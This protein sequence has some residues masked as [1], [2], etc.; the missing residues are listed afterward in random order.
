VADKK[1]MAKKSA[2]QKARKREAKQLR[3][4]FEALSA[5]VS[6]LDET[7]A[8]LGPRGPVVAPT[9]QSVPVS[10]EPDSPDS[11]LAPE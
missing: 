8:A 5:R 9:E 11:D 7:I 10:I 2:E 1:K 3:A 4:D 6:R